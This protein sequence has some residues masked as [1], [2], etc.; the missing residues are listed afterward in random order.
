MNICTC[1]GLEFEL[2]GLNKLKTG[3]RANIEKSHYDLSSR[4]SNWQYHLDYQPL[5]LIQEVMTKL[6]LCIKIKQV[7]AVTYQVSNS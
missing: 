5:D 3:S 2:A 1:F 4:G 6:C 7:W